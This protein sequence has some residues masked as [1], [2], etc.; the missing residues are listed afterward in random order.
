MDFVIKID[1]DITDQIAVFRHRGAVL[2]AIAMHNTYIA[3][4][5][6]LIGTGPEM[7]AEQWIRD[8][9]QYSDRDFEDLVLMY[10]IKILIGTQH[11]E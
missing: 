1:C 6:E 11:G 3:T 4:K 8:F 7:Y 9:I 5:D 2:A 10:F